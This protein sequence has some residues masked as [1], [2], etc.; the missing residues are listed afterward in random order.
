MR[1]G[2][3]YTLTNPVNNVLFYVGS[4]R[5]ALNE[6]LNVH[7]SV[8]RNNPKY[9][10][11]KYISKLTARPIIEEIES[12]EVIDN[13]SLL[14]AELFWF[15][16]L[17]AWS[18]PLINGQLPF[19][20]KEAAIKE[21]DKADLEF[22][23]SKMK[24]LQLVREE[25]GMAIQLSL[26]ARAMRQGRCHKST[27]IKIQSII[28]RLRKYDYSRLQIR[29]NAIMYLLTENEKNQVR[30]FI[31]GK[32]NQAYLKTGLHWNTLLRAANEGIIR[33]DKFKALQYFIYQ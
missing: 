10:T 25:T 30:V 23:K 27:F 14:R 26:L 21:I 18:F 9:S 33:Q 12:Y 1:G 32:I 31:D 11:A 28:D 3:I 5:V 4:T 2:R 15:N 16:Q 19:K 29:G 17:K 6:R 20:D 24:Y 22:L 8:A 7:I 13:E